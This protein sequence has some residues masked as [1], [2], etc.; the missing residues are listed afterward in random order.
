MEEIETNK[1]KQENLL[2]WTDEDHKI[3][4]EKTKKV[5]QAYKARLEARKEKL[6]DQWDAEGNYKKALQERTEKF[7]EVEY[8]NQK[9]ENYD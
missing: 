5:S 8:L 4:L 2:K 3:W 9:E 1:M 6:R 7:K